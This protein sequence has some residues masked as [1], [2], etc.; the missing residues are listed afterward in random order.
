MLPELWRNKGSMFTPAFD[1]MLDRLFYGWPET[2]RTAEVIW[3]PR[4]DVNETDKEYL[5]DV[6]VPGLEKKDIKVEVKDNTLTIS[7]ER[8]N[9]RK[10]ETGTSYHVERHYGKFERSFTLPEAVDGGK[11]SAKY[12]NGILEIALPKSEKAK[13]KEIAV[14]VK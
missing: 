5:L 9:E 8:T 11:V 7:G 12:T 1:D 10:T 14:E 4:V 3:T 13:P 2:G 6:E